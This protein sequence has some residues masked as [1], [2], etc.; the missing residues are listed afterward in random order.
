MKKAIE[1]LKRGVNEI[2][3]LEHLYLFQLKRISIDAET[4][5]KINKLFSGTAR[6]IQL[7]ADLLTRMLD[8]KMEL[9]PH[10]QATRQAGD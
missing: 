2:E 9:G 3:E 10:R 7:A 6:E 8:K 1:K 4:E 5:E